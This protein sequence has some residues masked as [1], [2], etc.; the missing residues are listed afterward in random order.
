MPLSEH[1]QQL[2]DQL[3]RQ[4]R[5][6]DP[7][8]AQNIAKAPAAQGSGLSAKHFV[9]GILVLVVGIGVA[10]ASIFFLDSPLSLVSGV[11]GF[12]IMVFGG[13]WAV[14]GTTGAKTAPNEGSAQ[15]GAHSSKKPSAG[16]MDRLEDRW[17][18]RRDGQG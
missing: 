2:L 16:L 14:S 18:K 17:D 10:I 3:E 8:F 7:R 1:E 15:G 9:V 6:E 5:T 4:L 12:A 11:I 13:Y